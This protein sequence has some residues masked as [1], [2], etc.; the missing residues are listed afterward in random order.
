MQENIPKYKLCTAEPVNKDEALSHFTDFL[1]EE[2]IF[3]DK[4]A[5]LCVDDSLVV[6]NASVIKDLVYLEVH[7]SVIAIPG[8][9]QVSFP[10]IAYFIDFCVKQKTNIKVLRHRGRCVVP[11]SRGAIM[12]DFYHSLAWRRAICYATF[13]YRCPKLLSDA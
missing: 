11:A 3:K 4:E 5:Y 12:S 7:C 9:G 2:V 8:K 13:R 10:A 6:L 1:S